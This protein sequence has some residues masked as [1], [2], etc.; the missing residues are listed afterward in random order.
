MNQNILVLD[1]TWRNI[2]NENGI[3]CKTCVSYV[4]VGDFV[5]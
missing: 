1:G 5:K 2:V 3:F 4:V